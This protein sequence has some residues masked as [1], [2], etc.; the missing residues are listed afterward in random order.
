[1]QML[2]E[3]APGASDETP[4]FTNTAR[5]IDGKRRLIAEP[6]EAMRAL[7]GRILRRLARL[8]RSPQLLRSSFGGMRGRSALENACWHHRNKHVYQLDIRNAYGS[9]ELARLAGTL[10]SLDYTLGDSRDILR[11][12]LAYCAGEEGG[13]ATGGSA[14][15]ALFDLYCAQNIDTR[16]RNDFPRATYTR[17]LDDLTVSS[18]HPI[19]RIMRKRIRAIVSGAGFAVSHHKSHLAELGVDPVTITGVVLT[20]YGTVRPTDEFLGKIFMALRKPKK[21]ADESYIRSLAG[22]ASWLRPFTSELRPDPV[23]HALY[24]RILQRMRDIRRNK[25]PGR[26]SGRFT[27][28]FLDQLRLHAPI[29]VVVAEQVKLKRIGREVSGLCPFHREHTPSFRVNGRKGFYHC[30]GCGSHGDV[31]QFTMDVHGIGFRAAVELLADR[32]AVD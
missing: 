13:L 12:L 9:V 23:V 1:M 4:A 32:Y 26:G 3:L 22:L 30:F 16:I 19:P 17:Y 21:A 5:H 8:A 31:I 14:S 10:H 27:V 6:N 2:I 18:A 11:F 28:A 24:A 15:P 29:E 7:H 20:A 25:V